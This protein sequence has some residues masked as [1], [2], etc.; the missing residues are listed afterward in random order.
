MANMGSTSFFN[1]DLSWLKF[2]E[3]IL[4]EA[5]RTS[6]PVLERIKFLSIFSSNLDEFYRV[7]MPV[8]LA[9]EKLSNREDND[10]KIDEHLLLSANS[11][12]SEQQQRYGTALKNS[13]I[14]SLSSNG[15]NLVYGHSYPTSVQ[16]D[17]TSY[18]LS[19][20][21][22]FLQPVYIDDNTDFFPSNNE[23]YFLITLK[24][25]EAEQVVVL[26]IPSTELP[27]F[28]QVVTNDETVVVFLDDIIRYHLDRIFP[29]DK[30]TGCFSFKITRDAEIDLKDE[31][32]GSLS[33]QLE[34]QLS[35][36]DLGFATRFLY[37]P[38]IPKHVL[39]LVRKTFNLKK[40]NNIEGGQYHNLKD[41][42]SFPVKSAPL[43]NAAWPKL[44]NTNVIDGTLTAAIEKKD[45][46]VHTPYQSYDSV[47]RF[48][49]EA[50]VD[51][52]V[53]EIYV[54][55]YRVASDS[56]IVNALI[57][58]AKNGKKVKVLVELKA[59]FDEANNIKWAK[60]MKA[61]GVDIIYSVTALKV[62]AKVALVKRLVDGRMRYVGLF[63]TGNFN[64]STAAFYTDH[65]LMTANKEMLR[66]VELL[67]MFLSKRIKPT[68]DT[69]ID[70]KVLLVAQFNLQERFLSLIDR[71]I[72]SA[73]AGKP[74]SITIKM[75]NLEE[76]VL[77]DKLYEASTA[78]VKID[79][80]V[81]SICRLVP[82][83]KGQSENITITRIVDRYLEHG[84]I[85]VFHNLGQT[86]LYLGSADWMNRNIYRRIEVCFP[87]YSEE[88]K[89]EILEI[90]NIQKHDSAQ[91]VTIDAHMNNVPVSVTKTPLASQLGIYN[92]LKNKHNSINDD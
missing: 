23:L 48:F 29:G 65:I 67:F 66:E 31:Y 10:I 34:K 38:G 45:I 33:D 83:L 39:K 91:A 89:E 15:I 62:H 19:Q 25:N 42:M 26:N 55:L 32:S 71:E 82:G 2:N 64:E 87:I 22:A 72:A 24:R 57:S 9:L 16:Q 8:L 21:L 88:I 68:A 63:A 81:R 5:E 49:N 61:V 76:K 43:S 53:K 14:P 1:R 58:A 37:A 11:L 12:I 7:R 85:F 69:F 17:V 6:V 13:I 3:R 78:G 50:A 36:R 70:F 40:A 46:M 90:I 74:A 35:K 92:Y 73:R 51:E 20:V 44:C 18:F 59:R 52:T 4:M 84:R 75:N 77:I 47:L 56:K 28:Y 41:L 79:L 60:K 86:E 27:R 54:T 30:V 80:I